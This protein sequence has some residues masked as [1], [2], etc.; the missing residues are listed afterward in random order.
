MYQPNNH[1]RAIVFDFGGVLLDWNPRYLYRKLFNGDSSRMGRFLTE[2]DFVGWNFQQDKGCPFAVAV[3]ELSAQFPQY[4]DLIK[5][6]SERWEESIAGPIEATVDILQELKRAGYP[7]YGLSNWSLET[8]QR[9]RTKYPFF[10]LFE[11]ILVSGEVQLAKPDPRLFTLFLERIGR[12]AEECLLIDDSHVNIEAAQQMGF[13][14]IQFES[15]SQLEQDLQ[16][17]GILR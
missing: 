17:L 11:T 6:Y 5:A 15:S 4:A 14:T 1:I 9:V 7:L 13:S 3:A 12:L 2:I 8:Y 16:R 10:K